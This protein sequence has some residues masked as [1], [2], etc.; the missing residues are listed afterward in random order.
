MAMLLL[1]T[2]L[3]LAQE[4]GE[5]L[6]DE[7]LA[8]SWATETA[9]TE[10]LA[11]PVAL[12]PFVAPIPAAPPAKDPV[13]QRLF[14]EDPAEEPAPAWSGAGDLGW[15]WWLVGAL[16]LAVG[17][18]FYGRKGKKLTLPGLGDHR[19]SSLEVVAR[20]SLG[21]TGLAL[22]QITLDD[23]SV[24]RLL[25]G[26]GAQGPVLLS[27]LGSQLSAGR[28]A[29]RAA[30]AA[31]EYVE[32]PPYLTDPGEPPDPWPEYTRAKAEGR[33]RPQAA[34]RRFQTADTMGREG[35][36]RP[37]RSAEEAQ[38]LVEGIL[39]GRRDRTVA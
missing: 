39:S 27:D 19:K 10:V 12:P 36:L 35:G 13:Y 11:A 23:G 22:V 17:M 20:T 28:P 4:P 9:P 37:L 34:I 3:A 14:G 8:E 31:P 33:V 16:G 2:A 15:T 7:E 18:W 32:A 5:S 30:P 38:S 25:V 6:A 21:Q 24:Q 26:T 1:L 29:E